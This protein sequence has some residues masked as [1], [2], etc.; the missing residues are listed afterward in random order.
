[1]RPELAAFLGSWDF[2]PDVL[3]VLTLLGAGYVLGW[4]QVRRADPRALPA[5]RLSCYVGG[6]LSIAIALL[7][8]LDTFSEL[9]FLMHM[10]QHVVLIMLAAPLLLLGN[11]LPAF[12]WAFPE[13][14]RRR[15]GRFL[16]PGGGGHVLMRRLTW[17]P[18]VWVL[19]VVNLWAWHHPA[20]YGA[21]LRNAWV[22]DAEHL[23]FF[24]TAILFWWPVIN[25][26]P[27][28]WGFIP[29]GFRIFYVLG[30]ALQNTFLSALI[31]LSD[32]VIYSHYTSV[33]RVWG[34]TV[35]EDQ[36]MAGLIMWL[37]GGMMYMATILILVARMLSREERITEAH[38]N[39]AP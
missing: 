37:P 11:P 32:R 18:G 8:P 6:L 36:M 27:Q 30:A 20:A 35:S 38:F 12:L 5:W 39:S 26:A 1:M 17:M 9:L 28:P 7:S 25:P 15:A 2:R 19:Y 21:A 16:A 22:H 33:P 34:L 24:L 14:V 3:V 13:S 29:Y 31:T 4:T 10:A 23:A